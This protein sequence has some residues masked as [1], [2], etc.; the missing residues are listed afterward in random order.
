MQVCMLMM[1]TNHVVLPQEEFG[2]GIKLIYDFTIENVDL[3]IYRKTKLKNL[4][5]LCIIFRLFSLY[6]KII[7]R[8]CIAAIVRIA[9][10]CSGKC[11]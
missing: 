3:N 4:M 5:S 10:W 11:L 6:W 7:F 2:G 1:S 9:A 8:R